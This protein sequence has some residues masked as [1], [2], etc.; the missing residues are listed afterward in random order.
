VMNAALA[1]GSVRAV[2]ANISPLLFQRVCT[3]R[4]G[5]ALGGGW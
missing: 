4:G 1:D 2:S 5:E 3:P